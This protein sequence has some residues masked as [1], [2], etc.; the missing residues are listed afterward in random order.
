MDRGRLVGIVLGAFVLAAIPVTMSSGL[1]EQHNQV[2]C[3]EVLDRVAREVS[4]NKPDLDW[5]ICEQSMGGDRLTHNGWI[6]LFWG[7]AFTA[8]G[9]QIYRKK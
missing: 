5:E 3:R 2:V 7:V 1:I 8:V 9:V 6:W 4:I